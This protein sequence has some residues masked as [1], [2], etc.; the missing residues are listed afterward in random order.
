MAKTTR[1]RRSR[2]G[3]DSAK[4][5]KPVPS[6]AAPAKRTKMSLEEHF[7]ALAKKHR[8]AVMPLFENL[9]PGRKFSKNQGFASWLRR[10]VFVPD[11]STPRG[12]LIGIHELG[13]ILGPWQSKGRLYAEAGAWQWARANALRWG[14]MGDR[15]M[16]LGLRSHLI[17]AVISQGTRHPE[18]IPERGH[19][20]W[21]CV[22][23]T[24]RIPWLSEKQVLPNWTQILSDPL[25]P[26]CLCCRHWKGKFPEIETA[27]AV[28]SA[29]KNTKN[30][31][32]CSLYQISRKMSS[33]SYCPS[34]EP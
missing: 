12:Y 17:E 6:P 15:V 13:H 18:R 32:T 21:E 5:S 24:M 34:Y 25:R 9:I 8:V 16:H 33:Q 10:A 23:A 28:M 29:T 20:L 11:V 27:A 22:P 3:V 4:A 14:P 30:I 19:Y 31:G 26:R 1:R 7:Y 2:R